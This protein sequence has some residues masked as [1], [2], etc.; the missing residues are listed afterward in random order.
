MFIGTTNVATSLVDNTEFREMLF[1]LDRKYEPP[2]RK[3]IQREIDDISTELQS[4]ITTI[5]HSSNR[6]NLCADIW[7]KKGMTASFLGITAHCFSQTDRKRHNF[8]LAVMHF[9]SPHTATR[10]AQILDR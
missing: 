7:T 10:I 1:E 2:G 3:K 9:P 6:I 5:L 8:T 4:K